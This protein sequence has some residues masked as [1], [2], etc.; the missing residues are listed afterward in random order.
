MD[1]ASLQPTSKNSFKN[2][3]SEVSRDFQ[4]F[5]KMLTTQIQN[6]DP[7]SPMAADQFASQLASFTMVE[8]QTLTNQ[9][10]ES[11]TSAFASGGVAA[12]AS[13]VGRFALHEGPFEFSGLDIPLEFA[14]SSSG[15]DDLEVV[16]LDSSG[17]VVSEIPLEPGQTKANWDGTDREKRVVPLGEYTAQMRRVFDGMHLNIQIATGGVVEEVRFGSSE[18]ELVLANGTIVRDADVTTLR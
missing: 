17:S 15:A 1:I 18:T 7:L 6:Q 12:Y 3:Q 2:D 10:L 11:L 13:V 9:K 5:L 4:T 8:Q 16:I 14:D